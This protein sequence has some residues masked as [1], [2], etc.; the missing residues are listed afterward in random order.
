MNTPQSELTFLLDKVFFF[1]YVWSVGA[2]CCSTSWEIFNENAREIFDDV[3]PLL[4][5]PANGVAFDYYVDIE[6]G[7]F[8]E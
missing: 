2:S 6:E 5:L 7:I 8:S 1:C 4:G 3:C